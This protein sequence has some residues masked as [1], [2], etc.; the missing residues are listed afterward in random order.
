LRV[1]IGPWFGETEFD[2]TWFGATWFSAPWFSAPWFVA[3]RLQ[4]APGKSRT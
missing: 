1:A 3:R 4:T 2:A